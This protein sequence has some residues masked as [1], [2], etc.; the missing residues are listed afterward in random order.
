[1]EDKIIIKAPLAEAM[2]RVT[3]AWPLIPGRG[4]TQKE[5]KQSQVSSLAGR[6]GGQPSVFIAS[7]NRET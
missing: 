4:L 7:C 2:C 3:A 6:E 1:M 5:S